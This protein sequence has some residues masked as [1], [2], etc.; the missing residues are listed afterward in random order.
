MEQ[1]PEYYFMD[2]RSNILKI[3]GESVVIFNREAALVT[4]KE[5]NKLQPEKEWIVQPPIYYFE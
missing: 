5:L 3:N 2:A 4:L 1:E